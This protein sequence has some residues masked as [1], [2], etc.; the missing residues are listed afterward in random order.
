MSRDWT[1]MRRSDFKEDEGEPLVLVDADAVP[2]PVPA[3]P[4]AYGTDALFGE[5]PTGRPVTRA[6]RPAASRAPQPDSLF[7]DL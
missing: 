2:R 3:V 6:R 7:E 4:D 5:E 1:G